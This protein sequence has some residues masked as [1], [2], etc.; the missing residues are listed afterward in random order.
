MDVG[1][2]EGIHYSNKT[3]HPLLVGYQK[4][5][6]HWLF[7]VKTYSTRNYRLVANGANTDDPRHN[8]YSYISSI[9]SVHIVFLITD[10]NDLDSLATDGTNTYL[11]TPFRE[12]ICTGAGT[13]FSSEQ[14]YVM[15][16]FDI[17]MG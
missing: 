15:V 14:V 7:Y 6:Y 10:L 12:N 13:E 4:V 16:I 5:V 17:F 1:Y 2:I 9:E 11:N 3:A 8:T